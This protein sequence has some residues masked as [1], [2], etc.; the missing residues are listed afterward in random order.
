MGVFTDHSLL[1]FD[2]LTYAKISSDG[3][4]IVF[5]H[6]NAD[7]DNLF[8]TLRLADLSPSTTSNDDIDTDWQY[9]RDTFLAAVSEHIPSKTIKRSGSP[10]WIDS[11]VKHTLKIVSEF[12]VETFH[13]TIICYKCTCELKK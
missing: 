6:K 2:F 13:A 8:E 9:W 1:F 4:R 10:P 12:F 11:E 3:S 5:D 7:L